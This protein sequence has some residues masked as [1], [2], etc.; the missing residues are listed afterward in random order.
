MKRYLSILMLAAVMAIPAFAQP[1]LTRVKTTHPHVKHHAHKA[2][3]HH[4]PKHH[5]HRAA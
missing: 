4:A 2:V 1:K 5:R 3:R